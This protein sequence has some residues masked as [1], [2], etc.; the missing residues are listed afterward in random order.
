VDGLPLGLELAAASTRFYPCRIIAQELTQNLDVLHTTMMDIPERHRSLR[1]A[2]DHSWSLL[3]ELEKDAFRRLSV[4]QGEFSIDEAIATSGASLTVISALVDRSLIQRNATGYYLIQPILR[5]Y[6]S[7][8]LEEIYNLDQSDFSFYS[9]D[10]VSITR[11][12]LTLL[13]NKIL[14]RDLFKQSLANARRRKQYLALIVAEIN[15]I[16]NLRAQLDADEINLIIKKVSKTLTQSV[17]ECD[18][19]SHLVPGKFAIILENISCLEDG[20]LVTR[21]IRANFDNLNLVC[22]HGATISLSFG[23]SI[24]PNDGDD[25][26]DLLNC[27]NIALNNAQLEGQ[28]FKYYAYEKPLLFSVET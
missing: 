19:I 26:G 9:N 25:I 14:F 7:E 3:S 20:G 5:Q 27:A 23:I 21:K 22:S 28:N 8:K 12:P 16:N 15:D 11:D 18:I 1:A 6:S 4:F 24:F 17:R 2:F 10:S 13:P